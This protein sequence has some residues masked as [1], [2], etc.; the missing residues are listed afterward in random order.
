MTLDEETAIA[1]PSVWPKPAYHFG[2]SVLARYG[3]GE[4]LVSIVGMRFRTASK[5]EYQIVEMIDGT[6]DVYCDGRW[7][8][9][10]V[11]SEEQK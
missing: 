5:W 6:P 4:N 11:L 1:Y 9:E 7:Y 10:F 2:Q 3:G 8:P